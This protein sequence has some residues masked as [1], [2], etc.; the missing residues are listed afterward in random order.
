MYED[1]D[2]TLR[3]SRVDMSTSRVHMNSGTTLSRNIAKDARSELELLGLRISSCLV[4]RRTGLGH[5]KREVRSKDISYD[6]DLDSMSIALTR[7]HLTPSQPTQPN[8]PSR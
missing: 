6:H 7:L 1:L 8:D 4:L 3:Y 2:S 5:L